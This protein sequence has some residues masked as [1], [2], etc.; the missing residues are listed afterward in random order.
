MVSVVLRNS[1][2]PQAE[3]REVGQDDVA[4]RSVGE[5]PH[6]PVP[7]RLYALSDSYLSLA[8]GAVGRDIVTQGIT[9]GPLGI[10]G[11]DCISQCGRPYDAARPAVSGDIQ[12]AASRSATADGVVGEAGV[13][14]VGGAGSVI[15][16]A[17]SMPCRVIRKGAVGDIQLTLLDVDAAAPE[18]HRV[19]GEG[20]ARDAQCAMSIDFDAAALF[21]SRV[22]VEGGVGNRDRGTDGPRAGNAATKRDASS[23]MMESVMFNV[24]LVEMPPP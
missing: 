19:I 11:D 21:A 14:D 9:V 23:L 17:A 7:I 24:E 3:G 16:A 20:G 15:D 18:C 8:V 1:P 4:V 2:A 10:P 22:V 13:V 12:A 6:P 5:A